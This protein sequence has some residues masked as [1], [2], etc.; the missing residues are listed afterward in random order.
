MKKLILI[1]TILFAVA[2][3]SAQIRFGV[4]AGANFS[5][6][7]VS[8]DRTGINA[9]QYKGRFS[10]HFGAVM[11]Y[12]INEMFSIQPE[13]MYMNQ[14]S[15]LKKDN[16]FSMTDGH[17]TLNTLQL[18]VNLKVK[19]PVGKNQIF[20]YGGPYL[21][22][23]IYGKVAGK[24]DG[25][26]EDFELFK[27]GDDMKRLDYGVGVGVGMEINKFAIGLGNQ[28]GLADINGASGSKMKTGNLTV[29]VGYFF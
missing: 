28:F 1:A 2:N 10:Y 16:S 18:P 14:G 20:V 19:F 29:S 15:N 27:K 23:H 8:G 25:K 13:F 24:I 3:L 11:E 7:Y 17:V 22:Y 4:K 12:S 5:T 26:K 21:S 9:E 6:L